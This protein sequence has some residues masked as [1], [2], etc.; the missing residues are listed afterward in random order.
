MIKELPRYLLLFVV[1]MLL[2]ISVLNNINLSGYINPYIY[3]L[4]ILLLPFSMPGWLLLIVGFFTGFVVDYFT[5]TLGLHTSATLLLAFVRPTILSWMSY[6]DDL[7]RFDSPGIGSSGME[8]FVRYA[9]VA[10]LVHHFALFCFES[11]S[12]YHFHITLLRILLSSIFTLFFIVMI[13]L[14][15]SG[16]K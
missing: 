11:F 7:D 1:L 10:V 13:E 8:W 14:L 15:R 5:N 2:Q 6:R 3:I 12:F 4:F 9:V 16:R